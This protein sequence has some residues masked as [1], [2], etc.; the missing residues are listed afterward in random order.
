MR[1]KSDSNKFIS[2]P[3]SP[4]KEKYH[5]KVMENGEIEL[6]FDG[7]EDLQA[8][9][10]SFEEETNIENIITRVNNGEIDLLNTVAGAYIDTVGM[11]KTYAEVLQTVI[12][13]QKVFEA[14][15]VDIKARFDNDFN[16]WFAQM[17]DNDFMEKSGFIKQADADLEPVKDSNVKVEE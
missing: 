6:V 5:G 13:G 9:I 4:L 7:Y 2:N 11:P 10:D 12:D 16:K 3:G 17:G 8:Y 14:L 15:P 1:K